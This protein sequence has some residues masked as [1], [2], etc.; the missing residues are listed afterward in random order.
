MC[1]GVLAGLP[2]AGADLHQEFQVRA[3]SK[4]AGLSDNKVLALLQ[5]RDGYLWVGTPFGLARFDG[6]T[7][8]AFTRGTYPEMGNDHCKVLAEDPTG[9]LWIGTQEGLLRWDGHHFRRWMLGPDL[10]LAAVSVLAAT[11]DGAIWAGS[12]QH[13]QRLTVDENRPATEHP[14]G[15]AAFSLC[16]DENNGVWIG[17]DGDRLQ[18]LSSPTSPLEKFAL[19]AELSDSTI[20]GLRTLVDRSLGVL[21][22]ARGGTNRFATFD[23]GR[24]QLTVSLSADNRDLPGFFVP[25]RT[26]ALWLSSGLSGLV[27][28]RDHQFDRLG[29][30][31]TAAEDFALCGLEDREGNVWIG[32]ESSGIF[33]LTPK[34]LTAI[35]QR[36][37]LAQDKVRSLWPAASGGVWAATEGGL[38]RVGPDLRVITNW[39]TTGTQPLEKL[40]AVTEL[41]DGTVCFG[42][43]HDQFTLRDGQFTRHHYARPPGVIAHDDND[44]A[45]NKVRCFLPARDGSLWVAMPRVLHRLRGDEDRWFT[46]TN[47]LGA[48]DVRALIE[49]RDGTIWAGTAG[50]GLSRFTGDPERPF[51]TLTRRDGLSRDTVWSLLEDTDGVLWAGTD[52]GLNRLDHG[53]IAT[54]DRRQGLPEDVVNCLLEDDL[55]HLWVGH[56]HGLYRVSRSE[57]A[58]VAA[59][60]ASRVRCVPFGVADGM[61]VAECNGQTVTPAACKTADGRL[62][63][64]TPKGIVVVDPKTFRANDVPPPVV[65]ESVVADETVIFGDGVQPSRSKT[66]PAHSELRLPPGHA[67][68]LEFRYTANTFIASETAHFRHR[69]EGYEDTW[70]D[71][72]TRRLAQYIGLPPGSYRFRVLAANQHDVWN[73]T[74]ATFAFSLAPFLWQTWWFWAAI[75]LAGTGTV[76]GSVTWR[77]REV[78]RWHQ[79]EAG[80]VAAEELLKREQDLTRERQRIARNLH[81]DIGASLVQLRCLAENLD[82]SD[83]V[84]T[85]AHESARRLTESIREAN[86]VLRETL[87]TVHPADETLAGLADRLC[88]QATEF[89]HTAGVR[90]R[91][92]LPDE[93]SA[94]PLG[95]EHRR[96]VTLA[97]KEV[98]ANV[99]KHARATEVRLRVEAMPGGFRVRVTDNGNGFNPT[100]TMSGD[101]DGGRGLQNLR[102]RL[103]ALGGQVEIR[104]AVGQGTQVT[105]DVPVAGM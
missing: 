11:R 84:K 61:M 55:G 63:F 66:E 80:R 70:H 17:G 53:R 4:D 99:L 2:L 34:S 39:L 40:K 83:A 6:L 104:S 69:L 8:T 98:L 52:G 78:R 93:F 44:T 12:G 50:G 48:D 13:L 49:T 89:L 14:T 10:N 72:G 103:A 105:L 62:W 85:D 51:V 5:T 37:G 56:D 64:A 28:W 54:F 43:D 41:A 29:T 73:E 60:Q 57:L 58:A 46:T 86:R 21:L 74:G 100:A 82:R 16:P 24:W 32:T 75:G 31:W 79:I 20:I 68:F 92:D 23:K 47:G 1:L 101:S 94:C 9:H 36:E 45:Y 27:R 15:V 59:G 30:P 38:S 77:I 81:D 18:R 19:P 95:P 7:F 22:L 91:F 25:D 35:T 88:R 96:E 26:G 90:V 76:A 67:R 42:A 87:W 102:T 33:C 65:I 3:W 71:V 97:C